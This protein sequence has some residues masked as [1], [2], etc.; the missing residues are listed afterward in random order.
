MGE[1][2]ADC[3]WDYLPGVTSSERGPEFSAGPCL[4]VGLQVAEL[5]VLPKSTCVSTFLEENLNSTQ[6]SYTMF[7][8][9]ASVFP[10][11][12]PSSISLHNVCHPFKECQ[13]LLT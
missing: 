8:G 2:S 7:L 9:V 3:A 11:K 13:L 10:S 1:G 5:G 4:T 12:T 6:R